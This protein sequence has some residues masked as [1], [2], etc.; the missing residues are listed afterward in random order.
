[1]F[2]APP[3]GAFSISEVFGTVTGVDLAGGLLSLLSF[4][5]LNFPSVLILIFSTLLGLVIECQRSIVS[6]MFD[7]RSVVFAPPLVTVAMGALL[8][9]PICFRFNSPLVPPIA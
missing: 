8:T 2:A 3:L 7:R 4:S 1:M 9:A 5:I 6:I